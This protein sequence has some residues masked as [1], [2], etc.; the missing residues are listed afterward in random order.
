ML[1]KLKRYVP[2][3]VRK[4]LIES[5]IVYCSNLYLD[6]LQNQVKRLLKLQKAC[7]GFILNKY[8]TLEN[9]TK[10]KSLLVPKKVNFTITED[11]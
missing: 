6:L 11:Y 8:A 9:I 4:Q 7:G 5:W 10:L 2:L 1:K 3:A